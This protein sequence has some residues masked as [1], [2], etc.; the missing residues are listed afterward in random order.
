VQRIPLGPGRA[1]IAPPVANA[2]NARAPLIRPRI[3]TINN[4]RIVTRIAPPIVAVEDEDDQRHDE[5]PQSEMDV[6]EDAAVVN[7]EPEPEA[8]PLVSAK[9]ME[10]M[11]EESEEEDIE[12][13]AQLPG[14]NVQ[15]I[16]P[17][18]ATDRRMKCE[19]KVQ[20]IRDVFRDDV[21][22]YDITMVSEYAEEIF[23]YMCDLEVSFDSLADHFADGSRH[24]GGND[25]EP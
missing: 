12:T 21:D 15:R 9:G 7:P 20:A 11:V 1:Q 18:V 2:V 23:E 5:P 16:W 3:P 13:T 6:E 24:V 10:V 25:A 8:S 22:M 4:K 19:K 17:D 14:L